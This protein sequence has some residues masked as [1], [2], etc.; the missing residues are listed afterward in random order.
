[1]TSRQIVKPYKEG[2]CCPCGEKNPDYLEFAHYRREDKFEWN[3][4]KVSISDMKSKEKIQAEL[5]KGRFICIFCHRL[6]TKF[7]NEQFSEHML[8]LAAER[9]AE[10]HLRSE[11]YNLKKYVKCTGKMC[12]GR[13][14]RRCSMVNSG[15]GMQCKECM[16]VATY[17]RAQLKYHQY[18]LLKEERGE[19]HY[20]NLKCTSENAYMF[21]WDHIFGK[22]CNVSKLMRGSYIWLCNETRLCRLLCAKCHRSKTFLQQNNKFEEI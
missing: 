7:Q 17:R 9:C 12:N 15:R 4:K 11:R 1:M 3:G 14:R 5:Q 18:N 16:Q 20:C 2:V 8:Q 21:D 13:K 10:D 22:N 19:C 6:E